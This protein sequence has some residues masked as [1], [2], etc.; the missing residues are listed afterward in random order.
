MMILVSL[1][2]LFIISFGD[3]KLVFRNDEI[4]E[5]ELDPNI[6]TVFDKFIVT[7][8]LDCLKEKELRIKS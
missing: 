3:K 4:I 1:I 2:S 5:K 8:D 7:F 6:N